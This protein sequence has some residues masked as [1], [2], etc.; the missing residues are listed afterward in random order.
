[1]ADYVVEFVRACLVHVTDLENKRSA[2]QSWQ[3]CNRQL[4]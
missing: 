2:L 1:M 4:L 3:L